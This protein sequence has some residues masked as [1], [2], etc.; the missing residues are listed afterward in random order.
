MPRCVNKRY[1]IND[2]VAGMELGSAVLMESG[3]V[4][5]GEGTILNQNIIE[6]LKERGIATLDIKEVLNEG[7]EEAAPTLDIHQQKFCGEYDNMVIIVKKAFDCMRYFKE[8]PIN[9]MRELADKPI[10]SLVE[11]IGVINHLH[12]VQR[13]DDYTF[14]HSVN[15]AVICGV[16]GKW[17]GYTGT[18][19]KDLILAGLMHDV[20]KTQIPLEILNKPG[21]LSSDEMDIMK[22][23]TTHGYNLIKKAGNVPSGV[24]YGIL[25]HHERMDGTGYPLKVKS[26]KIHQYAKIIAVADIYDAMTSDKVYHNKV[27]PFT[28][29]EMLVGEM[30][31]KLDPG[32]CT[33]FL[34]N[35]R[36]Y[37]VGSVV[38]LNDGREAEVLHLG[39]FAGSRP[40]IRTSDDE[41][42]DLEKRKDICIVNLL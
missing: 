37:F 40:I 13:Q 35:V 33:V 24:V 2:V 19:L 10:E 17:L 22:Q 26:D 28:V 11:A 6:R 39:Q 7:S 27:T 1:Q 15:V 31:N 20:G 32:I 25:Q 18:E 16:L 30:F 12:M 21:K 4:A 29:V 9:E 8:V 34:N 38:R 23:H 5:L 36:D 3:K 14:H 41:F 42:I